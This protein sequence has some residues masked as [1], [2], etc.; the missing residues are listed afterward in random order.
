MAEMNNQRFHVRDCALVRMSTGHRAQTLREFKECIENVPSGSIYHHFWGRFLQPQFDEPEYNNDFAA[1]AYHGLHEEALAEKLSVVDPT[2]FDDIEDL[3]QELIERIEDYL[4]EYEYVPWARADDQFY[5]V[6][7]Q[8]VVLD[9]GISIEA[10]EELTEAVSKMS[11]G[12]IFYHFIDARR[13]T[14]ERTND[15]SAWLIGL[16]E[17]FE[18]LAAAMDQLDP[19]F[20]SLKALRAMIH[21]ECVSFFKGEATHGTS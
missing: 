5:F 1:W 19:Y 10:P 3:R 14:P 2:E 17:E 6:K 21:A 15:F 12:S 13:R 18:P 16:G 4:F 20:S 11:L 8:L 9:T 7:S